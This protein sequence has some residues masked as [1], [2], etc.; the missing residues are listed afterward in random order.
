MRL[1]CFFGIH[2]PQ[3]GRWASAFGGW[4]REYHC[5]RCGEVFHRQFT[6][7]PGKP[8]DVWSGTP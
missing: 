5:A 8:L 6:N 2:K 7:S 4:M 3:M 1:L